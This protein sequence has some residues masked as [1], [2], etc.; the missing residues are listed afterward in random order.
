M[1][2]RLKDLLPYYISE[3]DLNGGLSSSEVLI[4]DSNQ[5]YQQPKSLQVSI[6]K[7]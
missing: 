3:D 2:K 4:Q 7:A 1:S 6:P 5:V